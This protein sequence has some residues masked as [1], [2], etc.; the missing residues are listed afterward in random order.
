MNLNCIVIDDEKPAR[1]QIVEYIDRVPFLNFLQSFNNAIEPLVFIN[2]NKV[3]VIF[4]DIEMEDFTGLQFAKTLKEKPHIILTT[5]YDQYAIEAFD[6]EVCDYLLKPI[7]FE[8]F[9]QSVNKVFKLS[10]KSS[11]DSESVT[12]H[13][14]YAFFKVGYKMKRIDFSD[15]LFIEGQRDYLKIITND[16]SE[17]ILMSFK[18]IEDILPGNYF[19]RVHKSYII[20]LNKID[21]INRNR[22]Y[23]R[24]YII[25]VG[26]MFRK[27]FQDRIETNNI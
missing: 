11:T 20:A 23:I 17:M 24:D 3:D 15:I 22:V 25:P 16:G 10:S 27:I 13:K 9:L 7:S 14:N 1:D 6:L 5:A 18:E 19:L 26:E 21:S 2:S 8:R 4:L 12:D